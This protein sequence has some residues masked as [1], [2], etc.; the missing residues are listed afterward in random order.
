MCREAQVTLIELNGDT[1][2]IRAKHKRK[3]QNSQTTK[4]TKTTKTTK[5]NQTSKV[6]I[7]DRLCKLRQ[8]ICET[9]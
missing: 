4:N 2:E 3:A 5:T 9:W 7:S 1:N 8:K 6:R